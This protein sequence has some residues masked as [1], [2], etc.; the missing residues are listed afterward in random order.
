M[1][2]IAIFKKKS[3]IKQ[4]SDSFKVQEFYADN[5]QYNNNNGEIYS[6][7]LKFQVI[8]DKTNLLNSLQEGE[9]IKIFFNIKG[10]IYKKDDGTNGHTQNLNVWKIEAVGGKQTT[11]NTP[12]FSEQPTAG[13]ED[14]ED[15]LPF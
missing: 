1:E 14:V 8:N 3:A 13:V 12:T 4:V 9:R 10:N 11:N 6:N 5:Q 15:D 7:I 2:I